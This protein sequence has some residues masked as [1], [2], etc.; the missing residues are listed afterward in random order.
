MA[1]HLYNSKLAKIRWFV[2]RF[3]CKE[4]VYKPLRMI[5]AARI[6]RRLPAK[7]FRY[8]DLTLNCFYHSY[9]MTWACERCVEVPI[10]LHHIASA[11][12]QA[13]LEIGNVL[14]HYR[15]VSHQILDKFETGVGVIN[16][17]IIGFNPGQKYDLIVSISTFEHIGFDD[18][19]Y[20]ERGEKIL[21]AIESCRSLLSRGGRFFMSVPAGYNPALD[22]LIINHR[23]G[24]KEAIFIKR[25]ARLDWQTVG[26]DEA[27]QC[28]FGHPYPYANAV[29]IAE[30]SSLSK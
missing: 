19:E 15:A 18:D 30:F 2:K 10:M 14:S 20:D 25:V 7:V 26:R 4:L 29:M 5:F 28:R 27:M 12:G 9:N 21:A 11:Q 13:V 17:D 23:L 8:K 1:Q 22:R 6:L 24:E 3:G 16:H